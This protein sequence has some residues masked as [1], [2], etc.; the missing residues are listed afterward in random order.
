MHQSTTEPHVAP[1]LGG[2]PTCCPEGLP[3]AVRQ[4]RLHACTSLLYPKTARG[5]PSPKNLTPLTGDRN[6][7]FI[8]MLPS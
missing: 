2:T 4:P 1:W 7:A 5:T 3:M 8:R 6:S